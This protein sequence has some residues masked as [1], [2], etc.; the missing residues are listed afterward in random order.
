MSNEVREHDVNK[1]N[2]SRFFI[3]QETGNNM[4]SGMPIVAFTTFTRANS[5]LYLQS[6]KHLTL[7]CLIDKVRI[8]LIVIMLVGSQP[9]E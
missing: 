3:E 7:S 1:T 4:P 9:R 5:T 8:S 2:V 6:S